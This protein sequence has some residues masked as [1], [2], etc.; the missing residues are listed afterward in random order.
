MGMD[1]AFPIPFRKVINL[2][3]A[4]TA[5]YDQNFMTNEKYTGYDANSVRQACS[6]VRAN[7]TKKGSIK[8][9][10]HHQ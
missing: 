10:A 7:Y 3:C 4:I 8:A 2:R 1:I 6:Y 5:G 9:C